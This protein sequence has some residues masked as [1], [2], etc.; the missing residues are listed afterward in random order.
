VDRPTINGRESAMIR[1]ILCAV[2]L[3][4][5]PVHVYAQAPLLWE[6]Q[7][8]IQGGTDMARAI[9]LSGRSAVVVGNGGVPLEGTDESDFV[10]QALGRANGAVQWTDQA[11]LSTGSIEPLYVTSRKN[12]AYAVGTLREPGDV[13]SAFLVRAYAVPTGTMLWENVWH[14]SAGVDQDHPTG[15]LATP[16]Q[17]VVVGYGANA[18]NDALA[19]LVR[20][21]DPRTGAVLWEDRAGSTG[22]DVI[23]R[24]I[25]ANRDQVFVA[26]TVSPVGDAS[27][28]DLF[29]RAYD[30]SSGD[31]N[32]E[33]SQPGIVPATMQL[34]SGR[35]LVA[36]AAGSFTYLA[37]FSARTGASLWD[38]M[39]PTPGGILDIAVAGSRIAAAISSGTGFAVRAY[40]LRTG[41]LEWE[42]PPTISAGFFE[43]VAAIVLNEN[44]V[45]A[46]GSAGEFFVNSEFLV[47]AYD[48]ADG[49]LLWDDRSHASTE[50]AAVDIALGKFRLFVA[51]YTFDSSTGT[52]FLIRAYDARSDTTDSHRKEPQFDDLRAHR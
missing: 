29:V 8:D 24:T 48:A 14:A 44:T 15:I 52:D 31:L 20:A 27:S 5:P 32:W 9:T 25:A 2:F 21:Y 23:A 13:R 37:A 36:G 49:S 34:A 41:D 33:I 46:A 40:S 1:R 26:G 22:V 18:T 17:V 50:T 47:R 42:V 11:F 10:I 28:G 45:Y 6:L 39:L 51:G 38:D 16:T 12:R 43:N 4:S 3:L 30:A 19:A 35:L 7:E